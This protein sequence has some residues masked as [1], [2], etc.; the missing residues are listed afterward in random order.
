MEKNIIYIHVGNNNNIGFDV[1]NSKALSNTF[2]LLRNSQLQV[3][4]AQQQINRLISMIERT[5]TE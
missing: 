4:K 5:K 1:N 3:I 2:D